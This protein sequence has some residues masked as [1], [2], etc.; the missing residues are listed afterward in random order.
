MAVVTGAAS[1]IGFGL[2]ERFAAEGM[3]VVMADVEQA[4]TKAAAS[5]ADSG[6]SVLPVA[7]DVA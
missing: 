2:A 3:H 1:G 6:A 4:L 5:I 7:T